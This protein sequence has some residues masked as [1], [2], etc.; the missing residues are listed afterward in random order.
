[1]RQGRLEDLPLG[2]GKKGCGKGAR[3]SSCIFQ[4]ALV[5]ACG[6]ARFASSACATMCSSLKHILRAR[7]SSASFPSPCDV[8]HDSFKMQNPSHGVAQRL[9]RTTSTCRTAKLT[10]PVAKP[11]SPY[12]WPPLP[13]H[14]LFVARTG[15]QLPHGCADH[16]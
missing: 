7:L 4:K 3:Q 12:L 8:G 11:R 6:W 1:M 10:S 14:R 2:W 13:S 15:L 5:I 9:V 16:R